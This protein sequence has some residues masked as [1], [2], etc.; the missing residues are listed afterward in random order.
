MRRHSP[1]ACAAAIAVAA[2]VMVSAV[3]HGAVV[4]PNPSAVLPGFSEPV[5]ESGSRLGGTAFGAEAGTVGRV[6]VEGTGAGFAA[7]GG[8]GQGDSLFGTGAAA[9]GRTGGAGSQEPFDRPASR[10]TP[11]GFGGTVVDFTGLLDRGTTQ[12]L[13]GDGAG[14]ESGVTSRSGD[15]IVGGEPGL[16]GSVEPT[17]GI[18]RDRGLSPGVGGVG[19]EERFDEVGLP[20][21]TD[22]FP[23]A[24]SGS[25]ATGGT[26]TTGVRSAPTPSAAAGGLALLGLL[27]LARRRVRKRRR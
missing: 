18:E 13:D 14:L 25:T 4:G 3:A 24:G 7:S 5:F 12:R 15:E 21:S 19:T 10:A 1:P 8:G 9:G 11:R 22:P 26:G 17:F 23:G 16:I 20:V 6:G 27:G 2:I